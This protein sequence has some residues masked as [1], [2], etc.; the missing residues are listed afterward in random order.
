MK[1]KCKLCGEEYE[2]D[3]D[4]MMHV[5]FG[6]DLVEYDKPKKEEFSPEFHKLIDE[7]NKQK[8]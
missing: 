8:E 2:D 4:I 6:H 1:Y 3:N 5:T 7:M